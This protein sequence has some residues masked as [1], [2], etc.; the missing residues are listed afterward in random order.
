MDDEDGVEIDRHS[1][2]QDEFHIGVIMAAIWFLSV[3][4]KRTNYT[5]DVARNELRTSTFF[6]NL[7]RCYQK[8]LDL[9]IEKRDSILELLLM[10]NES[11]TPVAPQDASYPLVRRGL[12]NDYGGFACLA[13]HWYYNSFGFPGRATSLPASLDS[14]VLDAVRTFSS[15]RLQ[16]SR[17]GADFPK[18]AAFQQLFN[19]AANRFLPARY[20]LTPEINTKATVNG[21]TVKGELDFCVNSNL[22]WAV[23]LLKEG[24]GIGEHLSRFD[25]GQYREVETSEYLVVDFRGPLTRSVQM[26]PNRCTF[27][28]SEDFASCKCQMRE[29]DGLLEFALKA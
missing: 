25:T 12:L 28:F 22:K 18:E 9:P 2:H 8:P 20:S 6:N 24:Q 11:I 27:Y 1:C 5:E 26:H 21:K 15:R 4:Y 29:S 17:N 19:E 14:L 23:E 10:A 16:A 7:H 13:A 3:K